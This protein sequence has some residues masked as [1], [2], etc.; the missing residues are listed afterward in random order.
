M[1]AFTFKNPADYDKIRQDDKVDLQGFDKFS[2]TSQW[3]V[4]LNHSDG[5][6]EKFE[7]EHNYNQQQI[8]WVKAGSALN[9]IRKDMGLS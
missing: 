9:K 2:P 1:L 3:F 6:T 7:V 5:S 4:V 8:E